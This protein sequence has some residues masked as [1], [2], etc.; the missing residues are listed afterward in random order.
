MTGS[1]LQAAPASSALGAE[2]SSVSKSYSTGVDALSA[3]SF[4]IA[5]GEFVFVA[6]ASGAG[7]T[8]LM[9]LL[10]GQER[11]SAGSVVL[12]GWDLAKA[13]TDTVLG[14]RR[15]MG[16]A[17]QDYKLLETRTVLE[18]VAFPLEVLGVRR[19]E[20]E[21]IADAM[22]EILDMSHAGQFFPR[23]LSG[24]EKQRVGLAR[25]LVGRPD[26]ILADEPSGNLDPDM[27]V[28]IFQ[29]LMEANECGATV[30][31]AT[32]D[33]ALIEELNRRTLVLD[34]GR[35]IADFARTRRE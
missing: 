8:T 30:V 2:L 28:A 9:K 26:L 6:G 5:P 31:V 27:T 15:R 20:R 1:A 21:A 25:A 32:H 10:A 14:L 29:L 22:L 24:G 4:A 11:A 12:D 17:F 34:K 23:A 33:L 13:D 35:L 19:A 7:K 3:V 18:N 16:I